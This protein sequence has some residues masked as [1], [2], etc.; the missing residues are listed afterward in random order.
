MIVIP[1]KK[2]I[3]IA[4]FWFYCGTLSWKIAAYIFDKF[5]SHL[6]FPYNLLHI[7]YKPPFVVYSITDLIIVFLIACL[8]SVATGKKITWILAYIVGIVGSPLYWV[9][10]SH[11]EAFQLNLPVLDTLIPSLAVLLILKP[12]TAWIGV[13]LGKTISLR[14]IKISLDS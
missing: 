10:R 1:I 13:T 6:I 11:F 9:I 12:L 3:L 5:S 2:K 4:V 14:W 7:P 8:M